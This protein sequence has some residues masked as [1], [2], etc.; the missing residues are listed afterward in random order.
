[1]IDRETPGI[2]LARRI[3]EA[4]CALPAVEAVA[5]GGS[6]AAGQ[7]DR[8]SDLDLYVYTTASIPVPDRKAIVE[9]LGADRPEVNQTFWEVG[10]GWHDADSG[11]EVEAVYWGTSWIEGMLERVLVQHRPSSGY[12][13]SHWYTIRNSICLYDRKR[14]FGDLQERSRQPYPEQLRQAIVAW[15]HPVLRKI[16]PSYRN[17]IDKAI[18]RNDL[19]S[20]NHRL[21]ALL[22]SYFDILFALN[23]VLHPGEK[24]LLELAA[25]RC[26]NVPANMAAQVERTLR[27]ASVADHALIDLIDGLMDGLDRLLREEGFAV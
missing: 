10:D 20:V 18:R 4:F 7:L 3:A 24:R 1:M 26:A 13:T 27:A 17:Q 15:N 9:R 8:D 16:T 5:L 2:H 23:R 25:E 19:V 12:T 11:I 22:A 6:H 14:W 21:A